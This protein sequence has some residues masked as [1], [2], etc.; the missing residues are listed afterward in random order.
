MNNLELYRYVWV[1]TIVDPS[2]DTEKEDVVMSVFESEE[3]AKKAYDELMNDEDKYDFVKYFIEEVP[4]F[5]DLK[6]REVSS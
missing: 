1:I 5:L 3:A 4:M 6:V 2:S